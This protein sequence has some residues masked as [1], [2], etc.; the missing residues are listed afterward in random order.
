MRH[1][2]G[3]AEFLQNPLGGDGGEELFT[4]SHGGKRP[5]W[6]SLPFERVCGCVDIFLGLLGHED[7]VVIGGGL[8]L[9]LRKVLF[10][11]VRAFLCY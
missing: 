5:H 9:G 8:R 6:G 2:S 7:E 11:V 10:C 1:V 3:G 4:L